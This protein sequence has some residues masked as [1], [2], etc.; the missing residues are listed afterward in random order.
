MTQR[1]KEINA[2]SPAMIQALVGSFFIIVFSYRFEAVNIIL[3]ENVEY[4]LGQ[5]ILRLIPADFEILFPVLSPRPAVV[6]DIS[7]VGACKLSRPAIRI[8]EIAQTLNVSESPVRIVRGGLP[9]KT[10]GGM[11]RLDER[12][13]IIEHCFVIESHELAARVVCGLVGL[14]RLDRVAK[15]E[16]G[17]RQGP[18]LNIRG[19]GDQGGPIPESNRLPVP[20]RN[21]LHMLLPDQYLAQEIGRDAGEE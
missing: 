12:F 11:Q 20:L 1:L 13:G 16:H 4:V 3:L 21:L 14:D 19:P 18:G 2:R 15:F 10:I 8:P 9:D 6:G 17:V 7:R 5:R